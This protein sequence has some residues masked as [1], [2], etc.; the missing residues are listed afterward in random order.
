MAKNIKA[1]N[2]YKILNQILKNYKKELE[3]AEDL[4][5]RIIYYTEEESL[6]KRCQIIIDFELEKIYNK[7]LE[8]YYI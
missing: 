5:V 1:N 3:E 6:S 2:N 7:K 8:N 4:L